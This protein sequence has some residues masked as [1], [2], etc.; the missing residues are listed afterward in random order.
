ML[1][2][3]NVVFFSAVAYV[4]TSVQVLWDMEFIHSLLRLSGEGS[5]NF[6]ITSNRSSPYFSQLQKDWVLATSV[7]EEGCLLSSNAT[8]FSNIFTFEYSGG[9]EA[10][11]TCVDY[12]PI[13]NSSEDE[14]RSEHEYAFA[15][16]SSELPTDNAR[17]SGQNF[18]KDGNSRSR[19]NSFS[20]IGTGAQHRRT[21]ASHSQKRLKKY[22]RYVPVTVRQRLQINNPRPWRPEKPNIYT[23]V[24]SIRNST[25]GEVLQSESCHFGLRTVDILDGTL[26]INKQPVLIRGVNYHEFSPIGGHTCS[27]DLQEADIKLMKRNN[28]N[29]LRTAHYPQSSWLYELCNVY[30][31][32][33]IDEANIETHGMGPTI[34]R[35]AN[36]SAWYDTYMQR[37]KRMVERDKGHVCIIGWSLGNDSG[38]GEIHDRMADWV[39]TRDPS[40]IVLYEPAS[41]GPRESHVVTK[42]VATDVLFP[43]YTTI[44]DCVKFANMHPNLPLILSAYGHMMGNSGGNLID[45]WTAFHNYPRLQGGFLYDWADQ[46]ISVLDSADR[47]MWAY[48]GDFGEAAGSS[49]HRVGKRVSRVGAFHHGLSGLNFPDRG[50]GPMHYNGND[51]MFRTLSSVSLLLKSTASL[52][53]S[54]SSRSP[55]AASIS[56]HTPS[57]HSDPDVR[58]RSMSVNRAVQGLQSSHTKEREKHMDINRTVPIVGEIKYADTMFNVDTAK[59]K[60]GLLEAKQCMKRFSCLLNG[61][62]INCSGFRAILQAAASN[63]RG[64]RILEPPTPNTAGHALLSDYQKYASPHS[65]AP[66][67]GKFSGFQKPPPIHVSSTGR[68]GPSTSTTPSSKTA[69]DSYDT[70][71]CA[72]KT[73]VGVNILSDTTS[74]GDIVSDLTFVG[75][76]LCDGLVVSC[77]P[78]KVQAVEYTD[79]TGKIAYMEASNTGRCTVQQLNCKV[80][81]NIPVMICDKTKLDLG[82]KDDIVDTAALYSELLPKNRCCSFLTS[83]VPSTDVLPPESRGGS[84]SVDGGENMRSK[85]RPLL[86]KKR[87]LTLQQQP[88]VAFG[89]PWEPELLLDEPTLERLVTSFDSGDAVRAGYW[90]RLSAGLPQ[91][92]ETIIADDKWK[93]KYRIENL[94]TESVYNHVFGTD[95]TAQM[96]VNNRYYYPSSEWS[97]VIMSRLAERAPYADA[98]FPMGFSVISLNNESINMAIQEQLSAYAPSQTVSVSGTPTHTPVPR[99]VRSPE[100]SASV[101]AEAPVGPMVPPPYMQEF[102]Q[103]SGIDGI[104]APLFDY[105]SLASAVPA[106]PSAGA[107]TVVP[108]ARVEPRSTVRK[109]LSVTTRP[110]GVVKYKKTYVLWDTNEEDSCRQRHYNEDGS[111]NQSD[112]PNVLLRA[113]SYEKLAVTEAGG[114]TKSLDS[115]VGVDSKE[116]MSGVTITSCIE[117]ILSSDT[118]MLVSYKIDGIDVFPEELNRQHLKYSCSMTKPSESACTSDGGTDA[119][120]ATGGFEVECDGDAAITMDGSQSDGS[121]CGSDLLLNAA[122]PEPNALDCRITP[123]RIHMHRAY[124][125]NDRM[126]YASRWEACGLHGDMLYRSN[127]SDADRAA[128]AASNSSASQQFKSRPV[129]AKV[130][131]FLSPD[132]MFV[133]EN[134]S[135]HYISESSEG[136]SSL[137]GATVSGDLDVCCG[138]EVS[139]E[140]KPVE[141]DDAK[142]QIIR[143]LQM[144]SDDPMAHQMF[145][146]AKNTKEEVFIHQLASSLRFGRESVV[147]QNAKQ[148]GISAPYSTGKPLVGNRIRSES[149][150]GGGIKRTRP[151]MGITVKLWKPQL[152]KCSTIPRAEALAIGPFGV[153]AAEEIPYEEDFFK[154]TTAWLGHDRSGEGRNDHGSAS[155]N[156]MDAMDMDESASRRSALAP[157]AVSNGAG[158][159]D[160]PRPRPNSNGRVPRANIVIKWNIK[161]LMSPS[162]E[163]SRFFSALFCSVL[164]RVVLR[165]CFALL[166]ANIS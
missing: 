51:G 35:L 81:F 94:E 29:A 137:S 73:S 142:I 10:I 120:G 26:C 156:K 151:P 129:P 135:L 113:V 43:M 60:P 24:M 107:G 27:T 28:I 147:I 18:S 67:A 98:G 95:E 149:G 166:I 70:G 132:D 125:D 71:V 99:N 33:V 37:L 102:L 141:V 63:A 58:M 93:A 55:S 16:D 139:F 57:V 61:T 56:S 83:R 34:G 87:V 1:A 153:P 148:G 111:V 143:R 45:Y 108:L 127:L 144:F 78:V 12:V 52:N 23:L 119:A 161:Y 6:D 53:T 75:L 36:D 9:D 3:L 66:T 164:C 158:S 20:Y 32:Y 47:P 79:A 159:G 96:V 104:A 48:T 69:A 39:R 85:Q 100:A 146:V 121:T 40:R 163:V 17:K 134:I 44:D 88:V 22:G 109:S 131:Q 76:L 72:I 130:N 103:S 126:G 8:A 84:C 124:L 62:K 118:G 101:S 31:L 15:D 65:P 140:T 7:F 80:D 74:N 91:K 162:G 50:L 155:G 5:E 123:A 106:S 89:L 59:S 152:K 68:S 115:K 13:P 105:G 14:Q 90:T 49:V 133:L 64:A 128:R 110:A 86:P 165:L 30:G 117:A 11:A 46:G 122:P 77:S 157:H 112:P 97:L 25:T 136:A 116:K 138:V 4:N 54:R 2:V 19:S 92:R 82:A 150:G 21:S 114:N 145:I 42:D 154:Q 41:Y 160:R 38:Y